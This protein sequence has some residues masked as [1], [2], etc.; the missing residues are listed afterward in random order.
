[1]TP[2]DTK[3]A[4]TAICVRDIELLEAFAVGLGTSAIMYTGGSPKVTV[5]AGRDVEALAIDAGVHSLVS[6]FRSKT[7]L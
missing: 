4:V 2:T 5:D 6:Q 3:L 1:M 7:K